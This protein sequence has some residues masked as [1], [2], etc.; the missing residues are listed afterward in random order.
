MSGIEWLAMV[1]LWRH[2]ILLARLRAAWRGE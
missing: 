1:V 2:T